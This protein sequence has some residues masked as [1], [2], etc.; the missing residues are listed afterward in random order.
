MEALPYPMK[1]S[2]EDMIED[3][4]AKNYS[5]ERN[6]GLKHGKGFLIFEK[7]H[8]VNYAFSFAT[9]RREWLTRPF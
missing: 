1:V 6:D 8:K 7:D 9:G 3:D 4:K 2:M 5:G